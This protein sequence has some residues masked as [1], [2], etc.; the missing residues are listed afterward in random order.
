M[1]TVLIALTCLVVA[2][3]S[4][5]ITAGVPQWEEEFN[6]NRETALL[7]I[8]LFVMGFGIGPM[9]FAPLSE[10]VGRWPVYTGTLGFAVI[11]FIPQAL[12]KNIE[13]LLVTR[14]ICGISMSAPMTLVGGS[15][16]DLWY[17]SLS[18][19]IQ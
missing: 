12:A 9:M 5:V 19:F 15:L 3:C 1:C 14:L 13:T 11:F 6:V 7:A 8:T 10:V 16:A 18:N 17:I 2:L 4:S